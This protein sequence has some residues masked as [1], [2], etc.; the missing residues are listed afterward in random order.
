M[1]SSN[2]F[3]PLLAHHHYYH[4]WMIVPMIATSSLFM[5]DN[6]PWQ[7]SIF[8]LAREIT[9]AIPR[10]ISVYV[11]CIQKLLTYNQNELNCI[12]KKQMLSFIIYTFAHNTNWVPFHR[13]VCIM[14]NAYERK[15]LIQ[16]IKHEHTGT[17]A[18][19][20]VYE[21]SRVCMCAQCTM[22]N[23]GMFEDTR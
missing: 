22:Y 23:V 17:R 4:V 20:S 11:A 9:N 15:K 18:I 5:I 12:H 16:I 1:N 14:Y 19:S 7:K 3:F 10:R 6:I 8:I 2:R 21:R 13:F